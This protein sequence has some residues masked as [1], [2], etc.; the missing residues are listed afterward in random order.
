[1]KQHH[2]IAEVH[3]KLV[4]MNCKA[5]PLITSPFKI[6][7]PCGFCLPHFAVWHKQGLCDEV[8]FQKIKIF[9]GERDVK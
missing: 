5:Q 4:N 7:S 9:L 8:G 6:K 3:L 1:M 2:Q